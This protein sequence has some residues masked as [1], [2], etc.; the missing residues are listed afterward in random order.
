[1][2]RPPL[3]PNELTRMVGHPDAGHFDDGAGQELF[4]G[5]DSA[6]VLD[7]GC[8]CGRLARLFQMQP[9]PPARYLGLDLHRGM[10][11]W[12]RA[13]L[14]RPGWDFA[15]T[16]VRN[17]GLNPGGR[18]PHAEIPAKDGSFSLAVAW[19]VFTHILEP[20]VEGQLREV[21]RVLR[22]GG[23]LIST[24]FLFDKESCPFLQEFQNAL[25]CNLEDPTNAVIYAKS[26]VAGM[27]KRQDLVLREIAPPAI[28]GFQ[29]TLRAEKSGRG[30]HAPFPEDK[31]PVSIARPPV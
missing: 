3:P 22:P 14:G 12:C 13:N 28:R 6:S 26:H 19:S 2:S 31:A 8:G 20:S 11:E 7:L 17:A 1:M 15:H 30:E 21:S 4:P 10:L 5:T 23:I 16:D 9:Q 24:W 29:W 27:F 25:Y 18:L